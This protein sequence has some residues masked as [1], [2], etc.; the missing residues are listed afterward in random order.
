MTDLLTERD[1]A[2]YLH[3]SVAA[4]RKW[5]WKS[6]G[7]KFLKL[8]NLVRYRRDDVDQWLATRPQGGQRVS[9]QEAIGSVP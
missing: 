5:R 7:P 8:G 4:C 1:V 6:I 9:N 3:V 2:Q